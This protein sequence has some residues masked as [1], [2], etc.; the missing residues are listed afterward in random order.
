VG[1]NEIPLLV[2]VIAPLK[3]MGNLVLSGDW[4]DAV[5]ER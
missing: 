2:A 3:W 5:K 4:D 1:I